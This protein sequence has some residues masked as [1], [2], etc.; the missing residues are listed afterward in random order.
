MFPTQ[1]FID[2]VAPY[3]DKV[4]VTTICTDYANDAFESM[5][6]NIVVSSGASGVNVS[7]SASGKTLVESEWF[8]A[9]R[10]CPDAWKGK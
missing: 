1:E 3:T 6:G 10:D 2:R 7:C 4:Y 9:N 5:N 8:K